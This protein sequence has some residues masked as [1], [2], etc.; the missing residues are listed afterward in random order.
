MT[1]QIKMPIVKKTVASATM[2]IVFSLTHIM[3]PAAVTLVGASALNLLTVQQASAD[4]R[5]VERK[6]NKAERQL[7][8]AKRVRQ[9]SQKK[10]DKA[11]AKADK[12]MNEAEDDIYEGRGDNNNEGTTNQN[13]GNNN[14]DGVHNLDGHQDCGGPGVLC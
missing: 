12:A 3:T 1:N 10:I 6:L 11:H 5:F 7:E 2:G 13:N 14:G 8:K 9:R 4:A